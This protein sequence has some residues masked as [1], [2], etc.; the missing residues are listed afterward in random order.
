MNLIQRV[1]DI[2][3]K[4]KDTWPQI[5]AEAATPGSI[6]GGYLIVLA[7]IPAV[8][9]FIGLSL[10]GVG[11]FGTSLRVPI[12]AGL[13]NMVVSFVLSL[14]AVFVLALITNALAPTFGGSRSP[15]SALKVVAYGSTAGF[16]GGVFSLLP[17][18]SILG[19]L[20][21]LYSIYLLYTGLPVLMKCPPEKA[22][23]Y[24]A[25]VV[26]CGIVAMIVLGVVSAA[27]LPGAG[28]GMAGRMGGGGEVSIKTPGGEVKIDS[29]KMDEAAKAIEQATKRLEEAQKSGDDAAA[30]KAMGEVMGAVGGAIGGGNTAPMAAAD[31]K[32]LLPDALGALKRES[33]EAQSGQAMGI[34]GS[35]ARAT[36]V[37]GTKRVEIAITDMGGLAGLAA[38]AGWANMTVDRETADEIEKVYKQGNRTV[39]EQYRK[40]GSHG[41]Y[42][43]ILA[44]GVIVEVS[45]EQVDAATLKAIGGGL[46]VARIEALKRA[47][48]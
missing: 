5:D 20:A 40:D 22:L 21:A 2:L 16:V 10:V 41:E 12:A 35:N 43:M 6:Y 15:I 28:F 45:G 48:K 23:G 44:N 37:A 39:R 26:V 42:T 29:S 32:A 7:A 34:G 3:L 1:Q 17:A 8:A 27:V 36:Y 24:T 11:G 46:D 4:P 25:V 31:L 30:G 13:A 33:I 14:L 9:A 38:L 19:L 47:A 18:L